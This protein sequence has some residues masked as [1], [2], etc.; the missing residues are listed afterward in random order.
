MVAATKDETDGTA[1]IRW[2]CAAGVARDV[3]RDLAGREHGTDL[4]LGALE[5]GPNDPTEQMGAGGQCLFA[6]VG[7]EQGPQ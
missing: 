4:Q 1:L 6:P 3:E 5:V 7:Q 2:C